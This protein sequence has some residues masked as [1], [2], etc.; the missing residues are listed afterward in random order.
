MALDQ[1]FLNLVK[2]DGLEYVVEA[3]RPAAA[4]PQNLL[5]PARQLFDVGVAGFGDGVA[6]RH[7]HL[8]GGG[9]RIE[10]DLRHHTAGHRGG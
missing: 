1:Q 2:P 6:R 8:R 7:E 10:R 9:G 4:R 5:D 3:R